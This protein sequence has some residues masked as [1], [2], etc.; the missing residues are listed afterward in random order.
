M[1]NCFQ[2]NSALGVSASKEFCIEKYN[3]SQ[4]LSTE[5]FN[6]SLFNCKEIES[7]RASRNIFNKRRITFINCKKKTIKP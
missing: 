5:E 4:I 7:Y 2:E 3:I 1:R 6:S